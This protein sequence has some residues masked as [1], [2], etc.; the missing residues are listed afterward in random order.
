MATTRWR[1]TTS[2]SLDDAIALI[3]RPKEDDLA[4]KSAYTNWRMTKFYDENQNIE[5]DGKDIEYNYISFSCDVVRQG[6]QPI[7]DRTINY[8]GFIIAYR[9][10]K[11]INYII[12]KNS[13]AL[14]V[15]RR[16]LKYSGR[17]EVVKNNYQVGSDTFVWLVNRVYSRN[18]II[19]PEET[20]ERVISID[21]IKGFRGN[22]ADS[23]TTVS[24]NGE[25]VMNILSTLSF[26]LESKNLNQ[27]KLEL[28]YLTHDSIELTLSNTGTANTTC[29]KYM[30]EYMDGGKESCLA[31]LYLLIYLEIMP[32]LI[33]AYNTECEN[34]GWNSKKYIEFLTEV[35]NELT[36]KIDNKKQ[37]L[38]V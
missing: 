28:G 27:V 29:E 18:N 11:A 12:N 9:N 25:S 8:N 26:L 31:K 3:M 36:S 17:S 34:G 33:Q 14:K 23:G 13:D 16:M 15:L 10:G 30:G 19:D 1:D 22:S 4:E 37:T 32:R 5:L 38:A 35:A 21:A 2:N 20:G 7:E 24:A 6:D